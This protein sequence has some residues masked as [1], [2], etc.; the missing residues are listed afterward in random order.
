MIQECLFEFTR[1]GEIYLFQYESS[2]AVRD[3][4]AFACMFL[5]DSQVMHQVKLSFMSWYHI[6]DLNMWLFTIVWSACCAL[7][8]AAVR[9]DKSAF[10]YSCLDTLTN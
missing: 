7:D 5:S 2:V 10:D 4:V 9:S 1:E 3:R 8:H 6:I